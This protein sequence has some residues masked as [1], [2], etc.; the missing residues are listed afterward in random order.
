[1]HVD[2]D[3][4]PQVQRVVDGG[5]ETL[6]A[7][8]VVNDRPVLIDQ[9]GGK[10]VIPCD[11]NADVGKARIGKLRN[12]RGRAFGVGGMDRVVESVAKVDADAHG[13]GDFGRCDRIVNRVGLNASSQSEY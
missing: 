2:D 10:Q 9:W 7:F 8:V 4:E 13:A 3:V 1:M 6:E 12:L 11:G 5:F